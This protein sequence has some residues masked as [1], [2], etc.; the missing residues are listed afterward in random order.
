MVE[1]IISTLH[2]IAHANEAI[3]ARCDSMTTLAY[4]RIP[5]HG[6]RT[7][8]KHHYIRDVTVER[9]VVLEHISTIV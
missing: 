2:I 1:E 8:S 9:G 3:L 5:K 7:K 6:D 4:T